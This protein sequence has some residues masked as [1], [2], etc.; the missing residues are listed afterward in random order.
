[1]SSKRVVLTFLGVLK[2]WH[3]EINIERETSSLELIVNSIITGK[4]GYRRNEPRNGFDVLTEKETGLRM[5]WKETGG[6]PSPAQTF[7]ILGEWSSE[8]SPDNGL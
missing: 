3:Q 1:V 6:I 8:R 5:A 2:S 4:K 7:G